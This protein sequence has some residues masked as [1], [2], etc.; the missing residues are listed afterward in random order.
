M[1]WKNNYCKSL[2]EERIKGTGYITVIFVTCY[3]RRSNPKRNYEFHDEIKQ[4]FCQAAIFPISNVFD[5]L[6]RSG[7]NFGRT[8]NIFSTTTSLPATSPVNYSFSCSERTL[9]LFTYTIS[10]T[11]R[12]KK[13]V[14]SEI[15][16]AFAFT[17]CLLHS[18]SRNLHLPV[19]LLTATGTFKTK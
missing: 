11:K 8:R 2:Q 1:Y 9:R 12:I 18:N 19:G 10:H 16:W 15:K 6:R 4:V 14:C 17:L 5:H 13:F 7:V 3:F